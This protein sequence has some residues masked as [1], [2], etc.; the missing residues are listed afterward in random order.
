MATVATNETTIPGTT[1]AAEPAATP[2]MHVG[3]EGNLGFVE[4]RAFLENLVKTNQEV[5]GSVRVDLKA[6]L[7]RHNDARLPT[8]G[9][10][11]STG[12]GIPKFGYKIPGGRVKPGGGGDGAAAQPQQDDAP[13]SAIYPSVRKVLQPAPQAS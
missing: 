6:F 8:G 2:S 9:A 13:S 11:L 7:S 1:N 5:M 3:T 12:G 4:G 10:A